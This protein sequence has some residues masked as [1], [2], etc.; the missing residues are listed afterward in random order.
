MIYGN[1]L[2]VHV[3]SSKA[4]P[5]TEVDEELDLKKAKEE[6]YP[7]IKKYFEE[8]KNWFYNFLYK[9]KYFLTTI[10]QE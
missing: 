4:L 9:F 10:F 3:I 5:F 1:G 7:K 6:V 8:N 2:D